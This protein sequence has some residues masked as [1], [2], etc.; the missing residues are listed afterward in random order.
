MSRAR[1]VPLAVAL[2]VAAYLAYLGSDA[3]RHG[4]RLFY[5][6]RRP[7]AAGRA[8][9]H[10]L[11]PAGRSGRRPSHLVALEDVGAR[12][13]LPRSIPVVLADYRGS[14]YG[15]SMLGGRSPWVGN[16]RAADGAAIIRHGRPEPVRLVE[17]PAEARAPV[18]K[19]FLG[20]AID[21][22]PHFPVSADAPVEAFERIAADYPVF[23]IEP[24]V[25]GIAEVE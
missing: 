1:I 23:R 11:V 4:N 9:V 7:N 20:R 12:S 3:H 6:N 14:R 22:R 17:L 19:A 24:R 10:A 25:G 18:I 2:V 16:V 21:A 5:R 13:G 8:D 15:V